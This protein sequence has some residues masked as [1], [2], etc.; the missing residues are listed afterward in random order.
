MGNGSLINLNQG[1]FEMKREKEKKNTTMPK[2]SFTL[3]ELLVVIA[4][5]A[6]L[7]GMLLPALNKARDMATSMTCLN[8]QKQLGHYDLNYMDDYN[9]WFANT[10]YWAHTSGTV[11][12]VNYIFL[13]VK[14]GYVDAKNMTGS[15]GSHAF[16]QAFF[17]PRFISKDLV[18]KNATSGFYSSLNIYGVRQDCRSIDEPYVFP[19][20]NTQGYLPVH[21]VK[22]SN[23]KSTSS[24]NLHGCSMRYSTRKAVRNYYSRMVDFNSGDA[25]T[26]IHN[27]RANVWCLDGH[28]QS[29]AR[30]DLIRLGGSIKSWNVVP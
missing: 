20:P 27:G 19:T 23:F 7:A 9:G 12:E 22:F 4:I 30:T 28:A 10:P 8:R 2:R 26:G 21:Y 11:D 3:I 15:P 6:I 18:T 29:V 17:C 25:L 14:T 16:K 13:Y 1:G 5:I 24:F